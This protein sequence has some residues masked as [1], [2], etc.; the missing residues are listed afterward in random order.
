MYTWL[1]QTVVVLFHARCSTNAARRLWGTSQPSQTRFLTWI[2]LWRWEA[3]VWSTQKRERH[4]NC[5]AVQMETGWSRWVA[6]S[7]V[8]ATRRATV[9]AKVGRSG[10]GYG[11]HRSTTL[12]SSHILHPCPFLS[13]NLCL[14]L[15]TAPP[16]VIG[17][18]RPLCLRITCAA[19]TSFP[20]TSLYLLSFAHPF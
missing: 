1:I 7:A 15:S 12:S 16:P 4:P 3:R 5:T 2:P 14:P 18:A 9:T 20:S 6:A 10:R 11:V 17:V 13:I 8:L 19:P